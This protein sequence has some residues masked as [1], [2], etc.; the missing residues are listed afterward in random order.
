MLPYI[1]YDLSQR[2]LVIVDGHGCQHEVSRP[3][4]RD[5]IDCSEIE[6]CAQAIERRTVQVSKRRVSFE[7]AKA[8]TARDTQR[9]AGLVA[10]VVARYL[11][12]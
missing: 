2:R 12:Q 6:K 5:M 4:Q 11:T 7:A 8:D 3:T 9:V 10:K 1:L